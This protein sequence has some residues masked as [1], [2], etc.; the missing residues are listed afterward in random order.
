MMIS[1]KWRMQ[2]WW[3]IQSA[4]IRSAIS[5]TTEIYD[6]IYT[7]ECLVGVNNAHY[8]RQVVGGDFGFS[9]EEIFCLSRLF[10]SDFCLNFLSFRP[11]QW[12]MMALKEKAK[13]TKMW[14]HRIYK[15]IADMS[16]KHCLHI[17]ENS[18]WK[19]TAITNDLLYSLLTWPNHNFVKSPHV[20]QTHCKDSIVYDTV[21][22]PNRFL[23][24]VCNG[25]IKHATSV[26]WTHAK[27]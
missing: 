5:V 19:D 26:I 21:M 8:G 12:I 16:N 7:F 23:N 22:R 9:I 27:R 24:N 10:H 14:S 20:N 17:L 15:I 2:C 25:N 13:S 3:L 6:W 11:L 4:R 1:C 18:W